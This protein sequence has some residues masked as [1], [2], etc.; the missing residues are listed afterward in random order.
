[1]TCQQIFFGGLWQVTVYTLAEEVAWMISAALDNQVVFCP[2]FV[3]VSGKARICPRFAWLYGE[4]RICSR[5]AWLFCMRY[6]GAS[7]Q[8]ISHSNVP[9]DASEI[10][11]RTRVSRGFYVI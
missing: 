11:E 7:A 10:F 4:A 6:R 9:L 1:M 2:R 5:F 8:I 3:R